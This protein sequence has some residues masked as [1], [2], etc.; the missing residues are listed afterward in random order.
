MK[1]FIATIVV[2]MLLFICTLIS[3]LYYE[4]LCNQYITDKNYAFVCVEQSEYYDLSN[5]D[6][7]KGTYYVED[8][9]I[10]EEKNIH[11]KVNTSLVIVDFSLN[12]I[13]G[14]GAE[15]LEFDANGCVVSSAFAEELFGSNDVIGLSVLVK[16]KNYSIRA[17][18]NADDKMII[19]QREK[20]VAG[21]WM[22]IESKEI[23][24]IVIDVNEEMYRGQYVYKITSNHGF[25]Y[26][27][28]YYASDYINL[29]P[30][31][32]LPAKLSDFEKWSTIMEEWKDISDRQSYHR[33]DVIET[34][35]YRLGNKIQRYRLIIII[36][37]V[38]FIMVCIKCIFIYR[39]EKGKVMVN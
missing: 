20:K 16:N 25:E 10:A 29:I 28:F 31:C 24:G 1:K 21:D 6:Y 22:L 18:F 33:K 3:S 30:E 5:E 17:V 2:S 26:D 38:L 23:S 27:N 15:L 8:N 4:D 13:L 9:Q 11:K 32:N 36:S 35:Y 37:S 34:F 19:V 7:V 14:I 39:N 12:D